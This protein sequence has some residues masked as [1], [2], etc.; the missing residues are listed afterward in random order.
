MT[1]DN[2]IP[3]IEFFQAVHYYELKKERLGGK[4]I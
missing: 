3:S 2:M 1:Q 4:K